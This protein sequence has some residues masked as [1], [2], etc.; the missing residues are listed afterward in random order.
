MDQR[1]KGL[2]QLGLDYVKPSDTP[3]NHLVI[4]GLYSHSGSKS[5]VTTALRLLAPGS[6]DANVHVQ[7]ALGDGSFVPVGFDGYQLQHGSVVT[8]PL[9]N[10]TTTSAFGLIIDSDQPILASALT[11]T[12]LS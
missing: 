5:S 2:S 8:I 11:T 3:Q 10:L 6:L 12:G 9:A 7:A 1:S 4:S